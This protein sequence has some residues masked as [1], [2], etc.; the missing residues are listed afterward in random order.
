[1]ELPNF[2]GNDKSVPVIIHVF[3]KLIPSE[4]KDLDNQVPDQKHQTRLGK[5]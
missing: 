1:M 4:P 3:Q 5:K 2:K